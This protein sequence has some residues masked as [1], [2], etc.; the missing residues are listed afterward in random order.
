[1]RFFSSI[2]FG[3]VLTVSTQANADIYL[4][5]GESVNVEGTKVH[6][7]VSPA[8]EPSYYC[9]CETGENFPNN[10]ELR[11][12]D[13]AYPLPIRVIQTFGFSSWDHDLCLDEMAVNPACE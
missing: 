9:A 6:C 10:W 3:F 1:M 11:L 8:P 12:Y 2:I 13:R 4:N 7:E 5:A